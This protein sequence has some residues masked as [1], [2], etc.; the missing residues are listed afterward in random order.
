MQQGKRFQALDKFLGKKS[1][2]LFV[3]GSFS[4]DIYKRIIKEIF[5]IL[6]LVILDIFVQKSS[7]LMPLPCISV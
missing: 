4:F 3:S 2:A 7:C 1:I 5:K 6:K